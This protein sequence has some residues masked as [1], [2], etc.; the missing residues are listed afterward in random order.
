MKLVSKVE[1]LNL[2]DEDES[3]MAREKAID[4]IGK[5]ASGLQASQHPWFE[6]AMLVGVKAGS[7]TLENV[8][9]SVGVALLLA[10]AALIT[11]KPPTV[12]EMVGR[13]MS[14]WPVS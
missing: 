3:R 2:E 5:V 4:F 7:F 1:S 12:S 10:A 11:L 6:P 8:L 9:G 13:A 14:V